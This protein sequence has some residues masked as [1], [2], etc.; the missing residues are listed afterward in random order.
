MLTML[1]L[2]LGRKWG[3]DADDVG[4]QPGLQLKRR[5]DDAGDVSPLSGVCALA[6]E[7]KER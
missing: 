6:V 2:C 3:Y 4:P 5:G 7:A 1:A